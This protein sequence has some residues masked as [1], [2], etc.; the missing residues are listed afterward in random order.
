[1]KTSHIS[2]SLNTASAD[3]R[4]PTSVND[5]TIPSVSASSREVGQRV[6]STSNSTKNGFAAA[7]ALNAKGKARVF[8][9]GD[10]V[11][12][13]PGVPIVAKRDQASINLENVLSYLEDVFTFDAP[14]A[15][16]ISDLK[17]IHCI[18]FENIP[19][20]C[21]VGDF[22]I[23]AVAVFN[24]L[25][26]FREVSKKA[27]DQSTYIANLNALAD[28]TTNATL[29][30]KIQEKRKEEL[31]KS[32][33]LKRQAEGMLSMA[34]KDSRSFSPEEK[35]LVR[36]LGGFVDVADPEE[37]CELLEK[38]IY[39]I[40]DCLKKASS[41]DDYMQLAAHI[42]VEFVKIHPFG[43]GNGRIARI[44][45][46]LILQKGGLSALPKPQNP[47]EYK[48]HR[49]A[50]AQGDESYFQYIK[51]KSLNMLLLP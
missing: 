18:L 38:L 32:E 49:E 3:L 14:K 15:S 26:A 21:P 39:D 1:M 29:L 17:T 10:E 35:D 30:S 51:R 33:I 31:A 25:D 20:D 8:S 24:P 44:L 41:P 23:E 45:Q 7:F 27:F 43:K 12:L 48:K 50:L 34:G 6:I 40:Q 22:R 16:I 11:S 13:R 19:I 5:G 46:N 37:I 47:E 42:Y 9:S 4:A 28:K 2:H 36:E